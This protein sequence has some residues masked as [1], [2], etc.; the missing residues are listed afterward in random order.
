MTSFA[1]MNRL[2]RNLICKMKQGLRVYFARYNLILN[3]NHKSVKK[4][5]ELTMEAMHFAWPNL[6]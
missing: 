2:F 4:M 1:Y 6:D 5:A 3:K